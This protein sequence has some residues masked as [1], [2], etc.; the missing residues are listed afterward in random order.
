F[1]G[2]NRWD[3]RGRIDVRRQESARLKWDVRGS[4]AR[5]PT[6]DEIDL[7][8]IPYSRAGART[9]DGRADVDYM[10]DERNS[11]NV[12]FGAQ[13]V[14]FDRTTEPQLVGFLQGGHIYEPAG[15]WRHRLDSR[16]SLGADY[17]FRRANVIGDD[18]P[19]NLH[20][21]LGTVSYDMAPTWSVSGAVGVV[22]L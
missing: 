5:V 22:Y 14:D 9:A 1:D 8:G 6:T 7:G 2:L 15:G 16:L 12:M 11:V 4:A 10:F 21:A 13:V 17:S 18:V 19:F 3:Q 20:S